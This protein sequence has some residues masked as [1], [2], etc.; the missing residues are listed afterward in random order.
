MATDLMVEEIVLR[1]R[2][3][4]PVGAVALRLYGEIDVLSADVLTERLKQVAERHA[5]VVV[6]LAGVTF[7]SAQGVMALKQ[8]RALLRARGGDLLL[9]R[10]ED[11]VRRVILLCG[12]DLLTPERHTPGR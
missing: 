11:L 7:I 12:E 8:A 2:S 9:H 6:G 4:H 1:D 10:A 3:E 5:I